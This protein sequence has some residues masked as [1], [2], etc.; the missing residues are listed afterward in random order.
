MK[1]GSLTIVG[2]GIQVGA[3]TTQE[4]IA[5]IRR[6]DRL[7]Y[8]VAD[9]LAQEWLRS[10]NPRAESLFDCYAEGRPRT[11]SY[12]IMVERLL[13]PLRQGQN[14]CAA[15]YGHPGIFVH[16][17]HAAIR[18]AREEGFRAVMLPAV[19]AEDCLFADLGVDPGRTGCQ[20]FEATDFLLCRRLF[21]PTSYLVLWQVG[22]IG[23][24]TFR[25]Q[26]YSRRG[27]EV[28][29]GVLLR[30]YPPNHPLTIYQAAVYQ[31]CKAVAEPCPLS[32]LPRGPVSAVST[33]VVP[34]L[35]GRRVDPEMLHELGMDLAV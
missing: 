13:A 25:H 4:A 12:R 24:L 23:D 26:G 14:V 29:T 3:Q 34:P 30:S 10:L 28:L 35:P 1:S 22:C 11:E 9:E 31:V 7:L 8:L 15:F 32:D 17:S 20:S 18:R 33:L 5:H 16:P 2:T 27:L 6:A 19:S 21:D